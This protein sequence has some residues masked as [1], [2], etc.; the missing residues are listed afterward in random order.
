[1]PLNKETKT[2]KKDTSMKPIIEKIRRQMDKKS[3]NIFTIWI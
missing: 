3:E 2:N 1:M